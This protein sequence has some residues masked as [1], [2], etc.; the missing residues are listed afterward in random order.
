MGYELRRKIRTQIRLVKRLI[1]EGTLEE[2]ISKQTTRRGSSPF[3]STKFEKNEYIQMTSSERKPS[4]KHTDLVDGSSSIETTT[5]YRSSY[6]INERKSSTTSTRSSLSPE[7]RKTPTGKSTTTT[8]VENIPGGT[9]TTT[10]KTTEKSFVTLKKAAPTTKTP[11]EDNQPEWVRQRNLRNSKESATITTKKTTSTSCTTSK[12]ERSS[13]VKEVKGTD[14][15][16]SSYGVGP[17]DENG[18][19]LFGLRALRAQNKHEQS[20]GENMLSHISKVKIK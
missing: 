8:T 9:R 19:P 1:T 5:D 4:A 6:S 12:K 16:T 11:V 18:T 2:Y 14:L 10:T 20:K 7:R 15:I 17:T 13:P 3:K